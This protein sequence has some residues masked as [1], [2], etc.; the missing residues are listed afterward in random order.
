M[1]FKVQGSSKSF[2]SGAQRH[3]ALTHH[4]FG[5]NLNFGFGF[6]LNFARKRR[7]YPHPMTRF[8][9]IP[10]AVKSVRAVCSH[11]F[12]QKASARFSTVSFRA[13]KAEIKS[14]NKKPRK[15]KTAKLT[16]EVRSSSGD[17]EASLHRLSLR[18]ASAQ[19]QPRSFH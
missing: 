10:H 6:I 7:F 4:W 13:K 2:E 11:T 16:L 19:S 9:P 14:Q 8:P 3:R 1:F 17:V 12:S 18:A 15:T 5:C